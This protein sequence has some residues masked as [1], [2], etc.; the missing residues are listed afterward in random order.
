[1]GLYHVFIPLDRTICIYGNSRSAGGGGLIT[2]YLA[3]K[4]NRFPVE[5][6]DRE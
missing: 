6:G 2:D 5:L 1:L 3:G 4:L